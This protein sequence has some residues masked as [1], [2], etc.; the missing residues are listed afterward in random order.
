MFCDII[1]MIYGSENMANK[2]KEMLKVFWGVMRNDKKYIN[3]VIPNC[4]VKDVYNI[5]YEE[6]YKR[7][8]NNIIFD[9]DNTLLPVNDINVPNTIVKLFEHLKEVGFSICIVS[10]NNLERVL[11]PARKLKVSYLEN[12]NKPNKEA[13]DKALDILGAGSSETVMVGDQ[14]LSDINGANEYGLY[15]VLVDPIANKYDLKTGTSRV[16]QKIMIKKLEKRNI[17]HDKHYYK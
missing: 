7:G 15:T 5:D 4:Y 11:P 14:L 2:N 8:Y 10:N 3:L 12:A 6:L 16:L 13:F 1:Q 17:F 9:I